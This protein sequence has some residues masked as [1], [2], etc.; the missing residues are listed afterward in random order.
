MKFNIGD[1]VKVIQSGR[2]FAPENIGKTFKIINSTANS[3]YGQNGYL[4]EG[5][6]N[7]CA[8]GR[9]GESS[10]ELVEKGSFLIEIW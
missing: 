8:E 7:S 10:F 9:V 4:V 1:T 3:Y 2:G 6:V 5:Y